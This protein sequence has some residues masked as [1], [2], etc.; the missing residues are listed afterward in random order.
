VTHKNAPAFLISENIAPDWLRTLALNI[1]ESEDLILTNGQLVDGKRNQIFSASVEISIHPSNIPKAIYDYRRIKISNI[2][3]DEGLS[4]LALDFGEHVISGILAPP[5]LK[6]FLQTMMEIGR[7]ANASYFAW[8]PA[9]IICD[10]EYFCALTQSYVDGGPFPVWPLIRFEGDADKLVTSNG[11][12]W[13]CGQE[14]SVSSSG[15]DN[16]QLMKRLARIAHD[17]AVNGA[18]QHPNKSVGMEPDEQIFFTPIANGKMVEIQIHSNVNS[19]MD[20]N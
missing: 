11:L 16:V 7:M 8:Q 6:R 18:I 20:Q 2:T 1:D 17:M 5:L 12:D 19:N 3:P 15:F 13:I 9:G 10:F 4:C 14:I